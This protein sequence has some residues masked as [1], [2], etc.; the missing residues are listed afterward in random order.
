MAFDHTGFFTIVGKYVKTINTMD[1]YL[2]ATETLKQE[3]RDAYEGEDLHDLY[4]TLPSLFEGFQSNVTSS[5][6]ALITDMQNLILD[7]NYTEEQLDA[8]TSGVTAILNALYT[9]MV[10]NSL[11]IESS[12]VSIGGADVN[13]QDANLSSGLFKRILCGRTL[14]GVNSPGNGVTAH[15]R[16]LG[17]ESQLARSTTVTGE[18]TSVASLSAETIQLYPLSTE[19]TGG[20]VLQDEEPS[21]G[22]SLTN[23]LSTRTGLLNA[24]LSAFTSNTPD[25][26][27]LSGG[28]PATDWDQKTNAI[29][30]GEGVVSGLRFKTQ[31]VEAKQQVTGL[32]HNTMYSFAVL[33]Q[34]IASDPTSTSDFVAQLETN[35]GTLVEALGTL[36]QGDVGSTGVDND[37]SDVL[38]DF[39]YLPET[40]DL[41][42]LYL[43]ITR[44]NDSIASGTLESN[45]YQVAIA[46]VSYW[47]GLAWSYYSPAS[48]SSL[49]VKGT[50]AVANNDNGVFQSFFRKAFNVQLPTADSPAIADTLAT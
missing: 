16:Y 8:Y 22:P 49:G 21:L 36:T 38:Y 37:N 18:V 6:Q 47:N 50:M 3:I 39:F 34:V 31:N 23:M 5:I 35:A 11:T 28:S 1:G 33:C 9:Y 41:D 40:V 45:I 10:D 15:L 17:A 48:Q 27:S 43:T 14:D 19:E 7:R 46:P 2:D 30:Q 26:W 29:A 32:S 25:N 12:V 4:A 20:Y 13:I 24:D 42:D 44:T